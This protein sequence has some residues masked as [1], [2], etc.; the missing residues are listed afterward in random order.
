MKTNEM[1]IIAAA[2]IVGCC[3]VAGALIISN[4]NNAAVEAIDNT[5]NATEPIKNIT[6]DAVSETSQQSTSS[7]K[8]SSQSSDKVW[9][10]KT[11]SYSD[12]EL[13]VKPVSTEYYGE[14][15]KRV[16]YEDGYFR[17]YDPKGNIATF[18]YG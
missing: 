10:E 8:S 3:I 5:T 17:I 11:Q 1:I 15:Y 2:V 6:E 9:N 18:G 7:S 4:E 14:G 12:R 16:S 13:P